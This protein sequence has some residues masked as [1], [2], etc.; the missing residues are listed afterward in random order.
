[1]TEFH[2]VSFPLPLAFG[3]SGGPIRR[4]EITQLASGAE[5]RNTA[6][7]QSRRRY[8][9]G[10]GIKTKSELYDLIVFFE[11]RFGQLHSF[12]FR[13]PT[14]Y[15]SCRPNKTISIT[16]Q[17][18]GLGDGEVQEF[19]LIK[20]YSDVAGTYVRV[21]TKPVLAT[22]KIAIDGVEISA[23]EFTVNELM[24]TLSFNNVPPAEAVISA[25]FE[26][27]VPVRF[28]TE[29]LDIS[30]EAFGAGQLINVPLIEVLHH[31]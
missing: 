24:G 11:S 3:A 13:D 4:T 29:Q 30:L 22:V 20:S 8:N 6:Y 15:K 9:A 19:Q 28:D 1:M 16:D 7:A 14:D 17:I 5:H 26:F 2:N 31:A 18:I 23:A 27:D 12:R 10:A 21:I 25:G